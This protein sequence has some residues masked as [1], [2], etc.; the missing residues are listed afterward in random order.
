MILSDKLVDLELRLLGVEFSENHLTI[1]LKNPVYSQLSQ[2]GAIGVSG[3]DSAE[4]LQSQL[5]NDVTSLLPGKAQFTSYCSHQGKVI[6]TYYLVPDE[7]AWI[8]LCS[9]DLVE[10]TIQKLAKYIMRSKVKLTNETGNLELFGLADTKSISL[11]TGQKQWQ[12]PGD[13]KKSLLAT[14]K[15]RPDATK[16]F[17]EEECQKIS[18]AAWKL[19]EIADGIPQFSQPL[20]ELYL[21]QMLNLDQLEGVSFSKGCYPGQE[22][23]ARA[24]YRGQVKRRMFTAISMGAADQG[25]V[26]E[27]GSELLHPEQGQTIGKVLYGATLGKSALL[28]QAVLSE[29]EAGSTSSVLCNN[30]E[31]KIQILPGRL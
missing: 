31:F 13:S 9:A 29:K 14:S 22:I 4:F 24:H 12:L 20:S 6:G 11:N 30:R 2:F 16:S 7:Q 1:T 15:Q 25:L 21:P 19:L 8:L 17:L 10:L 18:P 3:P 5:T 26:P 28:I 23:V 27:I